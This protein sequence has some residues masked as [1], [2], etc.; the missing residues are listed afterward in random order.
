MATGVAPADLGPVSQMLGRLLAYD[1]GNSRDD[2]NAGDSP[3]PYFLP[4]DDGS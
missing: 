3:P 4:L 2:G 1:T